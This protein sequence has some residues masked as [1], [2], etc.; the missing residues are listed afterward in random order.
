[1]SRLWGVVFAHLGVVDSVLGAKPALAT[2]D[3]LL[4]RRRLP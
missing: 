2:W 3:S 4:D 1:V